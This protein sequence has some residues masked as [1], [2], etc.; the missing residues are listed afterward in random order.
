[1]RPLLL[2]IAVAW[3]FS[4]TVMVLAAEFKYSI[5]A[6]VYYL[7]APPTDGRYLRKNFFV[8]A[9]PKG[10]APKHL[11][12]Y[13]D[14]STGP[15]EPVIETVSCDFGEVQP[16]WTV[17]FGGGSCNWPDVITVPPGRTLHVTLSN[18]FAP[19]TAQESP[20]TF[21]VVVEAVKKFP[22]N[23]PPACGAPPSLKPPPA[24]T[25]LVTVDVYMLPGAIGTDGTLD[26]LKICVVATPQGQDVTGLR[27]WGTL[28]ARK[29]GQD[30]Y[31][32]SYICTVTNA[33]DVFPARKTFSCPVKDNN[34]V[35]DT[36]VVPGSSQLYVSSTITF[37][38]ARAASTKTVPV[39]FYGSARQISK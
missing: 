30:V 16:G 21:P 24:K 35:P 39:Q 9:T 2:G 32:G 36:M 18:A 19:F 23:A 25:D 28:I 29:G 15:D 12:V 14:L 37:G 22:G 27:L 5:D 33:P 11:N 17:G 34:S 7:A 4:G 13:A 1:M 3:T 31:V 26:Q 10:F 6:T 38:H 8:T 20:S